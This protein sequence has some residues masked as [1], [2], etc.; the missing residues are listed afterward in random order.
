MEIW[1]TSE[2]PKS[3]ILFSGLAMFGA[4]LG[5]RAWFDQDTLRVYPM[6]NLLLVG[7]S[8]IGKSVTINYHA[9]WLIRE[10][11]RELQPQIVGAASV[12]KLHWD[13]RGNP[14]AILVAGELA[15]FFGRQKYLEGLVPYVTELLDYLPFVERRFKSTDVIIVPEPA[16]SVIGGS[17]IE[18]LQ[19]AIPDTAVGGGFLPR[20]LIVYEQ[21]KGQRVA[22]PGRSMGRTQR[23]EL[24]ERRRQ[25]V[26]KFYQL[27]ST[28]GGALDFRGYEDSDAY[29]VWYA[30]YKA[31][32]GHLSPFANR[33][34]E[35]VLRMA[36]LV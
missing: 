23:E 12:E 13:L 6:L 19:E 27:V 25:C 33:A 26:N 18:W 4:M 14:H 24:L 7:S 29:T 5:R 35:Y 31:P 20:F 15:N 32:S 28:A 2:P 34:G 8:G 22:L 3:Y 10:M 9:L 16:V 36:L 1:P 17:T 11:P 30:H 21:H